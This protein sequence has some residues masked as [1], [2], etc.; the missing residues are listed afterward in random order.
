MFSTFESSVEDRVKN[1]KKGKY[2][3]ENSGIKQI[4]INKIKFVQIRKYV[5]SNRLGNESDSEIAWSS[6]NVI[7]SLL[8]N[9]VAAF[10]K[11]RFLNIRSTIWMDT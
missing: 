5:N 11:G 7:P 8:G 4:Q 9:K 6:T 1:T 3:N 10:V 2:F